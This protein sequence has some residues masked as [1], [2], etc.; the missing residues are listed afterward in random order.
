[1]KVILLKFV[2]DLGREGDI[3][4]V[5]D[6]YAVNALFPKG[7]AKQATA[8]LINQHKMAQKSAQ[9]KAEKEKKR[10]LEI[11]NNLDGKKLVFYEKL[12]PKGHLYHA[13]GLKEIIRAIKE[14]YSYDVS[15][16]LFH[17][18]YSFKTAEEHPIDLEAYSKK[19][20]MIVAIHDVKEK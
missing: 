2:K 3:V 5:S 13:L 8:T 4:E 7:L 19:I 11:L 17:D 1:M 10:V 18:K 9:I 20:R 12:N 15:R 14:Q 16:D 6:G